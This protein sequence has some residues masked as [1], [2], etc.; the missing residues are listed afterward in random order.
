MVTVPVYR[1]VAPE[2]VHSLLRLHIACSASGIDLKYQSTMNPQGFMA[3]NIC[4]ASFLD[5]DCSHC[6]M[7]DSDMGFGHHN[8]TRLLQTGK[9]FIGCPGPTKAY[10][11]DA[12]K[13]AS[14]EPDPVPYGLRYAVTLLDDHAT[15]HDGFAPVKYFGLCFTLI[16]R[17]ALEAI[18]SRFDFLRCSYTA[19]DASNSLL[20]CDHVYNLCWPTVS[21]TGG[22]IEP[23]H[24]LCDRWRAVGGEVWADLTSDLTHTGPHTFRGDMGLQLFGKSIKDC[25]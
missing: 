15:P 3:R 4:F 9:P 19:V 22:Y 25:L 21:D 11:W 20:P 7:V 13:Q 23:D 24:T 18:I 2:F 16:H 10:N 17:F 12:I 14:T 5:S 1:D 8:L 6:L